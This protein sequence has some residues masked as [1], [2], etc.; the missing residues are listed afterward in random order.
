MDDLSNRTE[1]N[2]RDGSDEAYVVDDNTNRYTSIGGN[3]LTY[4]NAGNLDTDKDGYK[5]TYDY[6]KRNIEIVKDSSNNDAIV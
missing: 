2:L 5:Y 3:N 4:D 6:E 1:V